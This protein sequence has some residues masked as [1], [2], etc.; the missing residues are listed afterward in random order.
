M[1]PGSR[2]AEIL[3]KADPE[4]IWDFVNDPA[5]WMASNPEDTLVRSSSPR[6]RKSRPEAASIS[7]NRLQGDFPD[8]QRVTDAKGD[9]GPSSR[10]SRSESTGR[11]RVPDHAPQCQVLVR[12]GRAAPTV[13]HIAAS[14]EA[15]LIVMGSHGRT[16]VDRWV[17][18]SVVAEVLRGA[19]LGESHGRD[20][21]WQ[22]GT[23]GGLGGNEER[24]GAY[25]TSIEYETRRPNTSC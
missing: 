23:L 2:R 12:H 11:T 10:D 3:I 5:Q 8:A 15:D 21:G 20:S 25:S 9:Q 13:A 19:D 17:L 18:G 6:T 14:T 24:H 4:Q 16:L 22:Y 1:H 7:A